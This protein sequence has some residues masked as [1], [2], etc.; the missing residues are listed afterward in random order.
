[1]KKLTLGY[2]T[3]LEALQIINATTSRPRIDHSCRRTAPPASIFA[4][5]FSLTK[6]RWYITK[7][8]MI[9]FRH[10]TVQI[11]IATTMASCL[12]G[13]CS[14]ATVSQSD[15]NFMVIADKE[16]IKKKSD[17]AWW[18]SGKD[19]ILP[20]GNLDFG[21]GHWGGCSDGRDVLAAAT[22]LIAVLIVAEAADVSY[23]HLNGMNVS[24]QITG[25]VI[26]DSFPLNWGV[27]R[28]K[29]ADAALA[30]LEA[31]K[32]QLHIV[33]TGTRQVRILLPTDGMKIKHDVHILE[34]TNSGEII[35]DG[36]R[37]K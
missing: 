11:L 5:F 32:A 18:P 3:R 1:M 27:N 8:T 22:V 36:D 24:I 9:R 35:V 14:R 33:S 7:Q 31:G 30:A 25:N 26:N 37:V 23:H 16:F 10:A 4:R 34:F 17:Y 6:P 2:E 21:G 19:S 29:V 12:L 20:N 15:Y 13:G 28:F